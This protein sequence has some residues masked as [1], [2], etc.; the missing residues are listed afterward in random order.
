MWL[1]P[2]YRKLSDGLDYPLSYGRL[3]YINLLVNNSSVTIPVIGTVFTGAI[4]GDW[5]KLG[6]WTDGASVPA[7]ILPDATTD[8]VCSSPISSLGSAITVNSIEFQD[9][10]TATDFELTVT[11]TC[12]F[13]GGH[14]E[15]TING[16]CE[17]SG[18][19]SYN[20]GTINGV[21]LFSGTGAYDDD[22]TITG[23]AT[24]TGDSF[25]VNT[26]G[27]P[28]FESGIIW[29]STNTA[30]LPQ[31][32]YDPTNPGGGVINGASGWGYYPEQVVGSIF[33]GA[34]N[35]DW[36]NIGNWTDDFDVPANILP[37]SSGDVVCNVTVSSLG[38]VITVNSIDFK[39]S[40]T[41]AV[42]ALTATNG[43]VFSG[44][45]G[46]NEGTVIGGC[47]FTGATSGNAAYV[48]GNCIFSGT[49]GYNSGTITGDAEFSSNA[50]NHGD[51]SGTLTAKNPVAA[52]EDIIL[53]NAVYYTSAHIGALVLDLDEGA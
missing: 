14:N 50:Y 22:G 19:A 12:E 23:I 25:F 8:V 31:Y 29:D 37:I 45:G 26:T 43:C 24:F 38:S 3:S 33:T 18:T 32:P 42:N 4:D 2:P 40:F 48:T 17:F 51:I 13:T 9:S 5:S 10:F 20:V 35:G 46:S 21:V 44:V 49:D 7:T 1:P 27:E 41:D 53:A 30:S 11:T 36:T 47:S 52:F 34:I 16:D 39:A 6:N 15:G 28:I